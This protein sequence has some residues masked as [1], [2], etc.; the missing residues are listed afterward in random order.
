MR[1][2][3]NDEVLASEKREAAEDQHLVDERIRDPAE[4]A[5]DFPFARQVSVEK[6]GEQRDRINDERFV[7]QPSI[8]A[9]FELVEGE[10]R[11]EHDCKHES[12]G[13]QKIGDVTEHERDCKR[14][15]RK[16]KEQVLM[17]LL[18]GS[19]QT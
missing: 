9:A 16:E 6:I 5:F 7:Q 11:E 15:A 8:A 17:R 3:G 13:G 18:A 14:R 10:H 12:Q 4:G 1:W 2:I 19:I